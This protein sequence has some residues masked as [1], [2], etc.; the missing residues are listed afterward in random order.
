VFFDLKPPFVDST[1]IDDVPGYDFFQDEG[2]VK[3]APNNS[4]MGGSISEFDVGVSIG[5]KSVADDF[6]MVMFDV[7][8]VGLDASDFSRLGV[9]L[10][11][12]GSGS[13]RGGSAK[14]VGNPVPEPSTMLLLGTGL[15]GLAGWS[16][17]KFKKR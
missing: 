9:R 11:S 2:S 16:R 4:N 13:S 3:K 8:G 6:Q 7:F 10:Q 17:K 15:I 14:Y 1:T 12:V 5:T